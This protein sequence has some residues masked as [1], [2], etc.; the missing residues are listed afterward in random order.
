MKMLEKLENDKKRLI[1]YWLKNRV[2]KDKRFIEAFK[3]I[4]RENFILEEYKEEAYVDYPLP[5][6][7]G[8]TISQ[9]TTI[10]IMTQALELKKGHKVL[11]IGTGSG[12]QAAIISV[13]VGNKGK[14]ITTEIKKSLVDFAK[15]NLK[16]AG[17]KNVKIIHSDGSSGYE[18]EAP[19]DAIIVTAACPEIPKKLLEQLK[20][21]GILVAPVGSIFLQK[22]LKVKKIGKNKFKIEDLGEFRFVPLKGKFGWK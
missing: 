10:A 3:K 19:Y 17:I 11:E 22:M 1:E 21:G 7:E 16:K 6:L 18:R 12:Y 8:Q 4:R 9:P 15:K 13:I 2:V 20:I 14:V 5:I